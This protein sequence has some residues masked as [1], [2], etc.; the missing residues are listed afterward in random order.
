MPN[1]SLIQN[2]IYESRRLK[3]LAER[4]VAQIPEAALFEVLDEESNS[5]AMI[6]KHM[7]GNLASRWT[8]FL[9]TDG[10]KPNRDRESEFRSEP[11]DTKAQLLERWEAGWGCLFATLESLQPEDLDRTVTIRGE[12]CS[13]LEAI[14]RQMTHS[15]Y[16]VGQIVLLAKHDAG[17]KWQSL[18][19]PRRKAEE[20]STGQSQ[21]SR[22][23]YWKR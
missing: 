7:S 6:L 8:D 20:S 12:P 5:I 10:D 13:V 15:A 14:H 3:E 23:P 4:A 2:A 9:T 16:H 1:A 17:G 21:P 18:S 11:S 19:V 22:R